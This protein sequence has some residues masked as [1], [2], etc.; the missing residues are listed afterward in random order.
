MPVYV[1]DRIQT[2][3][4]LHPKSPDSPEAPD[5]FALYSLLSSAQFTQ[6]SFI[7]LQKQPGKIPPK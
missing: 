2:T 6:S 1:I 4:R 7:S 5:S 3:S